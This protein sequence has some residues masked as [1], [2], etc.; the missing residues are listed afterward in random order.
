[1]SVA[2]AGEPLSGP[3][4]HIVDGDTFDM[5][6]LRIRLWGID[7][8]EDDQPGGSHDDLFPP[9]LLRGHT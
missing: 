5:A 7:A 8:P 4:A 2:T 1:M 6:G 3:V 9:T